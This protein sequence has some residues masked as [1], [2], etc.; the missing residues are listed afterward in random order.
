MLSLYI[1][2]IIVSSNQISFLVSDFT[3][4]KITCQRDEITYVAE[5]DQFYTYHT[6]N[7]PQGSWKCLISARGRFFNI[8]NKMIEIR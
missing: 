4:A 5:T 7:L 3:E 8:V 1:A 2:F 6:F